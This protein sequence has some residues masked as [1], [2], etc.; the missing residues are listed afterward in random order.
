MIIRMETFCKAASNWKLLRSFT[1]TEV[2][3][4]PMKSLWLVFL[5][6]LDFRNKSNP[7]QILYFIVS[8]D[9]MCTSEQSQGGFYPSKSQY[10]LVKSCSQLNQLWY[11]CNCT[12][13]FNCLR[14]IIFRLW[15]S[16]EL[17]HKPC[18]EQLTEL[19]PVTQL[20]NCTSETELVNPFL[21]L[22]IW[23]LWLHCYNFSKD[24]A[25]HLFL[26]AITISMWRFILYVSWELEGN[27]RTFP[28]SKAKSHLPETT[29]SELRTFQLPGAKQIPWASEYSH[30][31]TQRLFQLMA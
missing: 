29:G 25:F 11:F 17:C 27:K 14:R 21:P 15:W 9:S 26:S 20:P 6:L 31:E 10:F 8:Q 4:S 16:Q 23:Y 1:K 30:S 22:H 7:I 13:L 18:P 19:S 2:V 5:R 28:I 24:S 12:H 3:W